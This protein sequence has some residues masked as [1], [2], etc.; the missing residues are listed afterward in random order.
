MKRCFTC[1]LFSQSDGGI[2]VAILANLGQL[3]R[4]TFR[5]INACNLIRLRNRSKLIERSLYVIVDL[6]IGAKTILLYCI[7]RVGIVFIT[8]IQ[9]KKSFN[10]YFT[11][12]FF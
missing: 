3:T 10:L 9:I 1:D 7:W 12:N 11:F 4:D 2:E 6:L 5:T 8:K